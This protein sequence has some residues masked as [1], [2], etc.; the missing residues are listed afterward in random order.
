M[1]FIHEDQSTLMSKE[2]HSYYMVAVEFRQVSSLDSSRDKY[3][4]GIGA[5]QT[6]TFGLSISS[7]VNH[8]HGNE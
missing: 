7:K 8:F 6:D 2:R 1:L 5:I 3:S 4:S